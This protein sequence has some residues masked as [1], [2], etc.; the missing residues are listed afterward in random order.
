MMIVNLGTVCKISGTSL[1]K[2]PFFSVRDAG[3][4][5]KSRICTLNVS[6]VFPNIPWNPVSPSHQAG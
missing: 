3:G 6:P 4:H 5:S 2:V 1:A